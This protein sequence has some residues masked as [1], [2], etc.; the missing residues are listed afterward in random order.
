MS[1]SFCFL[2]LIFASYFSF[3]QEQNTK[4]V[5]FGLF[6][7]MQFSSTKLNTCVIAKTYYKKHLFY[8]GAKTPISVNNIFGNF[9]VGLIGGYGYTL[10]ETK[11]WRMAPVL[12]IQWLES[13]TQNQGNATHYFDFTL[14]YQL[15]CIIWKGLQINSSCGYGCFY[16][17]FYN[18][19]FH[20]WSKS[21]GICG[22]ISLGIEYVF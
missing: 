10:L 13:K 6:G 5:Q 22:Q 21:T 3:S 15:T 14:N 12:D 11:R 1:R 16:K 7:G 17:R 9:P 19:F 18:N 4:K 2:L 20:S 8:V